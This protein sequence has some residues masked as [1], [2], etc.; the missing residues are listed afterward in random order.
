MANHLEEQKSPL[1]C[2]LLVT[3]LERVINE[4]ISQRKKL[5]KDGVRDVS[6]YINLP[7]N[8]IDQLDED[9]ANYDDKRLCFS[10]KH[11]C[12]FSCVACECSKSKVSCLRH[13]HFMCRCATERRYMMI[14]STEK[15][16][17]ETLNKAKM[18]LQELESRYVDLTTDDDND[19]A[20]LNKG[21]ETTIP[22]NK[23]V[24]TT[25]K[26]APGVVEDDE[27]HKNFSIDVS[28]S[29]P[30]FEI[31]VTGQRLFTQSTEN[32]QNNTEKRKLMTSLGDQR[33]RQL[34]RDTGIVA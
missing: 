22:L 11:I 24:E 8:R 19:V 31:P 23:G 3:E 29:S 30:L 20:P 5:L 33:K 27:I 10:C 34:S 21:V 9:S 16:M 32:D 2:K 1:T 18:R 15:E 14:W 28:E 6:E 25:M 13:S 12:F 17:N 4:E 26:L 7:P